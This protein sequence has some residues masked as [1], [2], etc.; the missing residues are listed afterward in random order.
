MFTKVLLALDGSPE[1]MAAIPYARAVLDPD[2]SIEA[3]HVREL[4]VGRGGK[5]TLHADEADVE[6]VVRRSVERLKAEGVQ[7]TMHFT[8]TASS[9]PAHAIA[10]AAR[11]VDADV[12]VMGTRGQ[13]Q[14]VGLLLGSVTQ[15]ILHIAPCPVLAVPPAAVVRE[16]A[17]SPQAVAEA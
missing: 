4:I 11:R 5:Q 13:S 7:A 9:G 2:G 8:T 1:A 17:W 14:V 6:E 10:E 12:I 3:V 16:R 15:R